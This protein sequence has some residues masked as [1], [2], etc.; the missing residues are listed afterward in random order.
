MNNKIKERHEIPEKYIWDIK[1]MYPDHDLWTDDINK[2]LVMAEDYQGFQGRLTESAD[3]LLNALEK[4]EELWQIM[5]KAFV[6][7]RMGRDQNNSDSQFQAMCDKAMSAMSKIGALTAFFT[8]ELLKSDE[9][10]I[11]SF[12]DENP[13]LEKYRFV[14]TNILRSK[15]HVLSKEEEVVLARMGEVLPATKDVFTVWNNVIRNLGNITDENGHQVELTAGNYIK[16]ME[17]H[18]RCVRKD[19]YE[20]MYNSHKEMIHMLSTTYHYNTK[21]D[22]VTAEL[23]KFDSS[24]SAALFDDNIHTSVYDN[25]V[26]SVSESLPVLHQYMELR[27]QL[28]GVNQL[29][30]YDVY[31]PLFK[32]P[33]QDIP[34]EAGIALMKEGLAP[35][36]S[37]Y[38]KNVSEGI[39][40]GWVD[41]YE[42]HGKTSGAYSFGSYDS[43][44]FILLNYT[45]TLNDVFT[46]VHEM[47]HSMHSY[48]TRKSQPFVYGSHSIF[49]AEVASTVNENLLMKHLIENATD[50]LM[51]KYLLNMHIEAFR[52]TLFR[53]TMFAE[54]EHQT[55]LAVEN[56]ETL[57]ADWLCNAY[58]ELNNKY[59]GSAMTHDDLIQYEWS[60]IPHFY[61]AFYV[62]KYATGYSAATAISDIILKDGAKDYLEFLKTGDSDHPI[63]LLKLAGVDMS[64][65]D[66]VNSAMNVFAELVNALEELI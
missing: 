9:T 37:D 21:V 40:N 60:R 16:Y 39:E 51:K 12:F 53:Q 54:F 57:T 34:Y 32:I 4:K 25:L 45:D 24:R 17:H 23:R 42:T 15:H 44:P 27:K 66:P 14:I 62:Y 43:K 59:F 58:S 33:Q 3:T 52:T 55:H 29:K 61:N 26:N 30:M 36:G 20:A 38:I 22:V 13:D 18:D 10:V 1:S 35:L 41:V 28:L 19:A 6:Y 48:Y 49:T 5:E 65:P 2:A 47:G 31:A 7:S 50:P 64:N 56:G 8:P 63:N 46:L 11:L